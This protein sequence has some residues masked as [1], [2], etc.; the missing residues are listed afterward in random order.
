MGLHEITW[1][2]QGASGVRGAA[3]LHGFTC[4]FSPQ[5]GDSNLGW[6]VGHQWGRS[7]RDRPPAARPSAQVCWLG[8]EHQGTPSHTFS[9]PN[10]LPFHHLGL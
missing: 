2:I 3:G 4:L 8:L 10:G 9:P 1:E 7:W 5:Q 6:V